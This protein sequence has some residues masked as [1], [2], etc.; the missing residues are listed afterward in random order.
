MQVE[1]RSYNRLFDSCFFPLPNS[2]CVFPDCALSGRPLSA[3]SLHC[4]K[5]K[6][7]LVSG[8]SMQKVSEWEKRVRLSWG[9]FIFHNAEEKCSVLRELRSVGEDSF[10]AG[11]KGRLSHWSFSSYTLNPSVFIPG[12]PADV[13]WLT[14][15]HIR[16]QNRNN[17]EKIDQNI[18]EL[19]VQILQKH[20]NFWFYKLVY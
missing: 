9:Q 3:H 8:A 18:H 5:E 20:S 4:Y 15:P 12:Q 7:R 14:A 11:Q 17:G 2:C 16:V 1:T 10:N 13:H 6:K 19:F